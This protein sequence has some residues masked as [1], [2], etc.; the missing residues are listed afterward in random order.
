[1]TKLTKAQTKFLRKLSPDTNA[2][3]QV[4]YE[5]VGMS[6]KGYRDLLDRKLIAEAWTW[7]S[8]TRPD[9]AITD[10]GRTALSPEGH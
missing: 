3:R 1:M 10:A 4:R 7:L 9:V 8:R 2:Y 6:F 5:D